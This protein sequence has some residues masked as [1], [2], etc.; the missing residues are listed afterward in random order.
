MR[1]CVL[2]LFAILCFLFFFFN[3]TAT[4]EIY[5]LSLHDAL[6]YSTGSWPDA[7]HPGAAGARGRPV[8]PRRGLRRGGGDLRR[9]GLLDRDD[10][11]PGDADRPVLPPPGRRDDCTARRQHRRQRRGPRVGADL[12]EWL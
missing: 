10:R 5:T 6:P 3:D 11:L 12:G 8:V 9:G 1:F 2:S 7:G 4:T